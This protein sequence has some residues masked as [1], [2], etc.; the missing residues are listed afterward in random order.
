LAIADYGTGVL[1]YSDGTDVIG[2]VPETP[3]QSPI[4]SPRS[5][6]PRSL[7]KAAIIS[8][9]YSEINDIQVSSTK[10]LTV[11]ELC[12][13]DTTG[14]CGHARDNSTMAARMSEMERSIG[15]SQMM[16]L[17]G[18]AAYTVAL[19][20]VPTAAGAAIVG[21]GASAAATAGGQWLGAWAITLTSPEI[22]MGVL[23]ISGA[24]ASESYSIANLGSRSAARA[25]AE[26]SRADVLRALRASATAEAHATAKLLKRG[27]VDLSFATTRG[28][29]LGMIPFGRNRITLFSNNI[30]DARQAAGVAAH[31]TRHWLQKLTPETYHQGHEVE[32][33]MWQ[34]KVDPRLQV[35]SMMDLLKYYKR[36]R[37]AP[38]T[39]TP[40][41]S[42]NE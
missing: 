22:F 14:V 37:K 32:A 30:S 33:F 38:I 42:P 24:I 15:N 2:S 16:G 5:Q 3:D 11:R 1:E 35:R 39:F 8:S 34:S 21:A 6:K 13:G 20:A 7:P 17:K 9:D 27:A 4:Q 36:L 40:K 25:G 31:E 26:L 18:M 12:A 10:A 23:G 41:L 19:F 28:R 29:E